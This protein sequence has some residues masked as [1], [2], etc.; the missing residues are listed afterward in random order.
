M[1]LVTT[2]FLSVVLPASANPLRIGTSQR[3][4]TATTTVVAMTP[5]TATTTNTY[6]AYSQP[7]GFA[8]NRATLFVQLGGATVPTATMN[9]NFEYSNDGVDWYEVAGGYNFGWATSTKPFDLAQV[10]QYKFNFASSTAGLGV[11]PLT[12]ATTTRAILVDTPT[13]YV[14]AIFSVPPG[15]SNVNV[16]SEWVPLRETSE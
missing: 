1:V 8:L 3:S 15:A 12:D 7:S 4:A 2:L 11:V 6:D 14:R 16:W 9:I 10:F 5:G 13:R